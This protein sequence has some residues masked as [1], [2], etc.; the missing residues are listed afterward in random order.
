MSLDKKQHQEERS[1]IN[2]QIELIKRQQKGEKKQRM[3]DMLKQEESDRKNLVV[4]TIQ[5]ILICFKIILNK[6]E[7]IIER[8]RDATRPTSAGLWTNL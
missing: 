8:V 2:S 4:E 5:N 6:E 3:Y 7:M 1:N